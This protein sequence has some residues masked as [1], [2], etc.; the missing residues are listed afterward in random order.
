MMQNGLLKLAD[1]GTAKRL[2]KEEFA[3]TSIGTPYY[4]SP[5]ML[6]CSQSNSKTDIWGLGCVLY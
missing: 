2:D 3:K 4:L 5:E 6:R 1:F